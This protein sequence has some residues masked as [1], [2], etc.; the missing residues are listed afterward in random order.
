VDAPFESHVLR[1]SGHFP[2][3]EVPDAFNEVLLS[4]LP[5]VTGTAGA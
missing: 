2:H 3:E 1:G 5:R 4:W